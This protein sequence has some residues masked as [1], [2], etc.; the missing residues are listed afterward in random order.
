MYQLILIVLGQ[1]VISGDK[2]GVE[3][4]EIYAKEA[5]IKK[6]RIL[7]TSG[8][9]HTKKLIDSKEALR[10]ELETVEFHSFQTPVIK[11][12]DGTIYQ[13]N[14]D[15]KEI[16]AN[17]IISPVQFGKGLET[18]LNMGIDT[19]IEIGPGKTLSGFV[20]RI[21]TEKEIN[22]LHINDVE[23]LKNTIEIVKNNI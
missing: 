3:E 23:S 7:K 2:E 6:V 22:I 8:P 17:H 13:E 21:P 4:A 1:I 15:I 14:D 19:F 11:N 9:F 10:N 12:L 5:G 16:L 18:M 20:K